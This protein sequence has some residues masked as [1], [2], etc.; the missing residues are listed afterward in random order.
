MD[1]I[2]FSVAVGAASS[3]K[4]VS[5]M[6][7][8]F[9]GQFGYPV[10]VISPIPTDIGAMDEPGFLIQNWPE[11]WHI[12]YMQGDFF[13]FDPIPRAV[14]T[15]AGPITVSDIRAGR[16]GFKPDPRSQKMFDLAIELGCPCGL[17]IP[18]FGPQGYRGV[19][20]FAGPG[21]DPNA[22]TQAQLHLAAIYAHDATRRLSL[23]NSRGSVALSDR[24]LTVLSLSGKGLDDADI[25]DTL[26]I[27]VR[28][29]RFHLKKARTKLSAGNRVEAVSTAKAMGLI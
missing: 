15:A 6:L 10:H 26:G 8:E 5:V 3:T 22:D 24:E 4:D 29:V 13:Q 19:V 18:I 12:A 20:C 1:A 28:T 11:A 14:S 9:G 7:A 2:S 23:K 17:I 27:S 16:A 25:A 21:P